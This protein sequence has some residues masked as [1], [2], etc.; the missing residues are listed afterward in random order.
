MQDLDYIK[1]YTINNLEKL[2]NQIQLLC[3]KI[4]TF[5]LQNIESIKIV[6]EIKNWENYNDEKYIYIF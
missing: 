4:I 5:D 1:K 6:N 3:E 2:S